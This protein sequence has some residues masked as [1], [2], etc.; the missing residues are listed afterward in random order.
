MEKHYNKILIGVVLIKL[1][2][3]YAVPITSDEAYF[4]IW[5]DRLD[6]NY[7]DHPPMTGWAVYLFGLLGHHIFFL[8]L[9]S[10]VCGIVVALG[11][12]AVITRYWGDPVK[13]R[14]VSL[15]FIVSPLHVLFVLMLTDTPLL[16]FG[17]LTGVLL[18]DGLRRRRRLSLLLSG[19]LWSC[20]VLSKYF[21]GLMLPAVV[22]CVVLA[23]P[24]RAWLINL[25]VWAGGAVPLIL[26]HLYW[27]YTNC[28]TNILFN[29]FNRSREV[30]LSIAGLGSFVVF[31]LYI[32]TPWLVYF[33]FRNR[34]SVWSG[35]K[36]DG[37]AFLMLYAIPVMII[38]LVSLHHTGLH[39]SLT[40]YP[41][42]FFLAVYFN[43]PDL[44]RLVR[45]SGI[46]S[47]IHV[48]PVLVVLALPVETFKEAPYYH[49]L[50]LC[51]HGDEIYDRLTEKYGAD[52]IMGTNGYYT[53]GAMAYKSR[54]PFIVFLDDSKHGRYYDKLVDYRAFDGKTI[55][56]L[57]TLPVEEDYGL[58]FE[59]LTTD[60]IT[61]RGRPFYVYLGEGFR[62]PAYRDGFLR[63]I[64]ETW[65][66]VPDLLPV[67]ECYFRQTY[68]PELS[69]DS[70]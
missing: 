11:L 33:F 28:W 64:L 50:V 55:L 43:G 60:T 22:A 54:H 56:I 53:S 41:F 39:W 15:L 23:L 34:R 14:L 67:G 29:V 46:F 52:L 69:P 66:A 62:Y 32:A 51:K 7:Y 48:I 16:L 61:V 40:F 2:L 70:G 1:A 42:L 21:A 30:T 35:V 6:L 49:D 17:F 47:L 31:Q 10:I 65:Y 4:Y 36:A 57:T 19:F 27:N 13:A 44:V 20:A 5:G 9:F 12:K 37:S 38:G 59:R 3:A 24:P 45:Y 68:F 18:F 58:Y 25:M 63:H 8:R 26:L